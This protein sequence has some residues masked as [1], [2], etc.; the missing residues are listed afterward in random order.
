MNFLMRFFKVIAYVPAL[1]MGVENLLGAQKGQDKATAVLSL[2]QTV[3]ADVP[4]SEIKDQ[5]AFNDGLKQI[6]D[7]VVKCLNASVWAKA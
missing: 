1:V 5:N 4:T 6:N 3:V 2:V 7:G